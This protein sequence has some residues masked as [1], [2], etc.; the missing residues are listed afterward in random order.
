M[1][2]CIHDFITNEQINQPMKDPETDLNWASFVNKNIEVNCMILRLG[3]HIPLRDVDH[4]QMFLS[5]TL[6]QIDKTNSEFAS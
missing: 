4:K 6:I 5:D 1:L 2:L 3:L